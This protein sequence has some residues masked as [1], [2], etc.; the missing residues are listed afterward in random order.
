MID[1]EE[2]DNDPVMLMMLMDFEKQVNCDEDDEK[3]DRRNSGDTL[4]NCAL[5]LMCK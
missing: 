3:N 1:E 5:L 2:D 4:S